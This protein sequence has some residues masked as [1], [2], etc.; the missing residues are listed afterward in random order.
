MITMWPAPSHSTS[1]EPGMCACSLRLCPI[2]VSLSSV[3]QMI[4]V[5]TLPSASTAWNLSRLPKLGKNSATT[6]NGVAAS[7][8]STNST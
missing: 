7:I 8:S 4:E 6:S 5:G 2:E 3:P 1:V